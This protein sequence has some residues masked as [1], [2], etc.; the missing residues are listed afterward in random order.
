MSSA[1]EAP[2]LAL[3]GGP[4][5]VQATDPSLFHWPIITEEDEAAVLEVLR[6]GKMSGIDVTLKFEEEMAAWHGVRYALAHNNGT[7][8]LQAAMWACGVRHGDEIIGPSLTY[9]A[10]LMPALNLGAR[11]VFADIERESLNIDPADVER[12]ITP[13]TKAI[14][15]VHYTGYPCDMD[16][17]LEIARRHKVK[18]IE[19]VSHAHGTLYKGRLAGTMGDVGC[20]SLM[21]GKSLA[22]GEGGMLI[23]NDESIWQRAAAFGHY[24]RTGGPSRYA[25]STVAI[26]DPELTQYAG[27]PLGGFKYRMHQLTSALGRVQL[28]HYAERRAEIDRAMNRF[29]DLLEGTPGIR[30]HRVRQ[31]N[32]SMGGWYYPLAHYNAEELGGLKIE[33]FCEALRAEGVPCAPGANKPL[34]LHSVFHGA[35]IYGTGRVQKTEIE[36]LPVSEGVASSIFS[37]P[38]FKHDR[39]GEIAAYANAINKV[40]HAAKRGLIQ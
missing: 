38:W 34:H 32:C 36:R 11:V 23:T 37:V 19:D 29:G 8:A 3:H 33:K 39:A 7:A 5:A 14:V 13:R 28:K 12:R 35:D 20:M 27:V 22:C 40:A 2:T 25:K 21:S 18:L 30:L 16:R 1:T 31:E 26:T 15:A 4:K 6:A 10:S 24:E 9:W 17:L